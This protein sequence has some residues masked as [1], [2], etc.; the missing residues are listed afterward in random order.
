[1]FQVR[2]VGLEE[3]KDKYHHRGDR[4]TSMCKAISRTLQTKIFVSV[5]RNGTVRFEIVGQRIKQASQYIQDEFC[6]QVYIAMS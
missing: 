3:L 6:T 2:F 5:A 4:I 1:M